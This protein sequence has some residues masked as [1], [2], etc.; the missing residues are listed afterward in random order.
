MKKS[1]RSTAS[2]S[3]NVYLSGPRPTRVLLWDSLHRQ[4]IDP[5]FLE[6]TRLGWFLLIGRMVRAGLSVEISGCFRRGSR[7]GGREPPALDHH[8][9]FSTLTNL[10][11]IAKKIARNILWTLFT[12]NSD[13]KIIHQAVKL[14]RASPNN[15]ISFC[16]KIVPSRLAGNRISKH[17]DL[18]N[19]QGRTPDPC[20]GC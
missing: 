3:W 8:I 7:A 11:T 2:A 9:C 14:P 13:L 18:T 19:F 6:L 4:V 15:S 1:R 16:T 12:F 17:L 10:W 5:V 20:S